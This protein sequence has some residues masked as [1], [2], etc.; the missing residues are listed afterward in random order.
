[1]TWILETI[2]PMFYMYIA[3]MVSPSSSSQPKPRDINQDP[4]TPSNST[5]RVYRPRSLS[6]FQAPSHPRLRPGP[7]HK[8]TPT[9]PSAATP[10]LA[11]PLVGLA[12]AAAAVVVG[13]GGMASPVGGGDEVVVELGAAVVVAKAAR[14]RQNSPVS[15]LA[16]GG[17]EVGWSTLVLRRS[18]EG[19]GGA[20]LAASSADGG[21]D[22][23]ELGALAEEVV[24]AAAG[25]YDVGSVVGCAAARLARTE[26]AGARRYILG[27][28]GET[29][30]IRREV[31][32]W[33]FENGEKQAL[34]FT[35]LPLM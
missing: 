27:A 12:A 29:R 16:S 9:T 4:S 10:I 17:R 30:D 33:E 5:I 15:F 1:M 6:I 11:D 25:C 21:L 7:S 22:R 31:E 32:G 14:A 28:V 2:P 13:G 24:A 34:A 3:G 26:R 19:G 35:I 20:I 18:G 8:P 23:V